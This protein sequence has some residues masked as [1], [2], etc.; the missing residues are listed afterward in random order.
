MQFSISVKISRN[1]SG[2]LNP[3]TL[4]LIEMAENPSTIFGLAINFELLAPHPHLRVGSAFE[5]ASPNEI[6]NDIIDSMVENGVLAYRTE[7]EVEQIK[8]SFQE[9]LKLKIAEKTFC[10]QFLGA[11]LSDKPLFHHQ[12]PVCAE[13]VKVGK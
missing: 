7:Y 12:R 3:G 1:F 11:K 2:N 6:S 13:S 4:A 5:S 9:S 8:I 10:L